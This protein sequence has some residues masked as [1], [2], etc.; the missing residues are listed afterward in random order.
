MITHNHLIYQAGIDDNADVLKYT[1]KEFQIFFT[2]LLDEI[3]MEVLIEPVFKFSHQK[4]WTGLIGIVT[5]HISFHFWTIEKY[6]QFDIYSCKDFNVERAVKFLND[7]WQ[8]KTNKT[9]FVTREIDEDFT[10]SKYDNYL[11]TNIEK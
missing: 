3:D 1:E 6:V 8:V 2:N 10:I 5:S 7:F 4:A 9:L 11:L